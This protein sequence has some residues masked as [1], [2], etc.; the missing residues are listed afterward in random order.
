MSVS[1]G[2]VIW[3]QRKK[4]LAFGQAEDVDGE[5]ISLRTWKPGSQST[6]AFPARPPVAERIFSKSRV[7]GSMSHSERVL[8]LRLM[9]MSSVS[10]AGVIGSKLRN[11][12]L[13]LLG[14]QTKRKHLL[15][16]H[17][18]SQPPC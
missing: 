1:R 5:D 9:S 15:C 7:R 18:F 16:D 3:Q 14:T 4:K 2:L 11:P 17:S 10:L 6:A 13:V 8:S 12:P